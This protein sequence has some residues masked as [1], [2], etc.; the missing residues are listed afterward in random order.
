[1]MDWT[2]LLSPRRLTHPASNE[3]ITAARN[4]F[5]KDWDRVVFS[6][7]GRSILAFWTWRGDRFFK[8]IE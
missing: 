4:P 8:A 7:A 2:K 1:M 6:S 5:Q 3:P